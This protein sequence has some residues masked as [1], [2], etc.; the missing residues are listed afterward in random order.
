VPGFLGTIGAASV[1]PFWITI[2]SYAWFISFGV[3][4]SIYWLLMRGEKL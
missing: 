3:S 4:F 1:A 2:Y